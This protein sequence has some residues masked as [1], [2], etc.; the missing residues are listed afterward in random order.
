MS[1]EET[2]EKVKR[3]VLEQFP[4]FTEEDLAQIEPEVTARE[5]R[6]RGPVARKLGI[7]LPRGE[8]T[9]RA[10]ETYAFS[11]K[12]KAEDGAELLRMVKVTVDAEGNIIKSTGSKQLLHPSAETAPP[13]TPKRP[14]IQPSEE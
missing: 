6:I 11:K 4:D 5:V 9:R 7:P 8:P 3:H 13:F 10:V 12:V 14:P 1:P 2:L